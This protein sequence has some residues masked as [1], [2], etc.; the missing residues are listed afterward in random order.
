MMNLIK[1]NY[2]FRMLYDLVERIL[3]NGKSKY[4][5]D[6]DFLWFWQYNNGKELRGNCHER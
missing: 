6:I 2:Y 1:L 4:I 5:K 3:N